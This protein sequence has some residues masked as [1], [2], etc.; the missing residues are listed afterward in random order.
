MVKWTVVKSYLGPNNLTFKIIIGFDNVIS[1]LNQ[2]NN[3]NT[4]EISKL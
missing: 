4:F 3:V 2:G 1:F